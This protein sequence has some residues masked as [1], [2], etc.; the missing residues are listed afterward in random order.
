[1]AISRQQIPFS[2]A[3]TTLPEQNVSR[4]QPF[5]NSE[6]PMGPNAYDGFSNAAFNGFQQ[7]N[8]SR[9]ENQSRGQNLT[10]AATQAAA[11]AMDNVRTTAS[12]KSNA[13]NLLNQTIAQATFANMDM[14]GNQSTMNKMGQMGTDQLTAIRRRVGIGKTQSMGINPDLGDYQGS[15]GQYS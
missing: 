1:M 4:N 5:L 2:V 14:H 8:N 3:Q 15:L 6:T 12:A 7:L 13:Q 10:T 9:L 11:G